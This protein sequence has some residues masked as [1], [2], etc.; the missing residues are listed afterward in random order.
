MST[1]NPESRLHHPRRRLGAALLGV[2]LAAWVLPSAAPGATTDIAAVYCATGNGYHRVKQAD[3]TYKPENYTFAEGGRWDGFVTDDSMDKMSFLKVA[4]VLVEPLRHANYVMSADVKKID[5]LVMVFWGTTN[6]AESGEYRNHQTDVFQALSNLHSFTPSGGFAENLAARG[7][8]AEPY[9]DGDPKKMMQLEGED[10]LAQALLMNQAE[11]AQ[12]DRN[13][14]R[15]AIILGFWEDYNKALDLPTFAFS[16]SIV[17]EL[18]AN[19][20]FVVLKAYDFQLLRT[21]K[22]KKLLWE[23]RFS[24]RERNNR[25]D[26]V[27]PV[28]ALRASRWFGQDSKHLLREVVPIGRV[29]VGTPTVVPHDESK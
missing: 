18:E 6:G 26:E 17:E 24:I 15:N 23:S 7:S 29:E 2:S 4:H 11:N 22:V 25:F 14:A 27:L 5:L 21:Q 8:Q 16:N 3:G 13:N 19:R 10:R 12:R 9:P 1:L 28:M 20:Y